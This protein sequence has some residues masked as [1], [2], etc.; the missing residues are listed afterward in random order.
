MIKAIKTI[1]IIFHFVLIGTVIWFILVKTKA[2]EYKLPFKQD[3]IQAAYYYD[4]VKDIDKDVFTDYMHI[5]PKPENRVVAN[6]DD[7]KIKL[8]FIISAAFNSNKVIYRKFP[9]YKSQPSGTKEAVVFAK[10]N[11]EFIVITRKAVYEISVIGDKHTKK[12]IRIMNLGET[13]KEISNTFAYKI[14]KN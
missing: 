5:K 13:F 11:S 1:F 8:K 4:E 12:I 3:E 2:L 7:D 14:T 10:N 9:F 6:K